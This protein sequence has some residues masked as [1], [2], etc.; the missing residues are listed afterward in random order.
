MLQTLDAGAN[1]ATFHGTLRNHEKHIKNGH[2]ESHIK[3]DHPLACDLWD[4]ANVVL[5]S[6]CLARSFLSKRFIQTFPPGVPVD[7]SFLLLHLFRALHEG[8]LVH[9]YLSTFLFSG[10]SGSLRAPFGPISDPNF[11]SQNYPRP[12]PPQRGPSSRREP[13]RP[14][15]PRRGGHGRT[16]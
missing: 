4:C 6:S 7:V 13:R 5:L 2:H 16:N 9:F 11:R 14:E 12:S 10:R 3:H 1:L 15:G 8:T